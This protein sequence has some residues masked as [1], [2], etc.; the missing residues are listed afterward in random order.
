MIFGL[1]IIFGG[2]FT[3]KV[4]AVGTCQCS[5]SQGR[6]WYISVNNCN[7]VTEYASGCDGTANSNPMAKCECIKKEDSELET[8]TCTCD[9]TGKI[10]NSSCQGDTPR[11]NCVTRA[12]PV[13]CYC[14]P[15]TSNST[16]DYIA[17]RPG[18]P[19]AEGLTSFVNLYN[20]SA[21]C[22]T[23]YIAVASWCFPYDTNG[24]ASKLIQ[25]IF[26]IAGGIAFLLM[27]YGFIMV[28]TASG[29]EKKLQAAKETITSAVT[30]LLISLFALFL[31]RL[32]AINILQ[33]PGLS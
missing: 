1:V 4:N 15:E 27:V 22:G 31:F 33:I 9:G 29:D 11:E 17:P 13:Y 18:T 21:G 20:P 12:S 32:I 23:G 10:T 14:S 2:F 26:G 6:T 25:I 19:E 28:A 30:G 24:I 8:N 3:K 7:P 5:M 16:D